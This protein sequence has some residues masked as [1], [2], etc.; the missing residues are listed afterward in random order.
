MIDYIVIS[1]TCVGQGIIKQKN[2]YPYNNPFIG[3]LIP[4][5]YDYIKLVNNFKDYINMIPV[6]GNVKD[7]SLF[8]KQNKCKYYIHKDIKTPYP[9]IYLAD[10]EIHF[11][12]ENNNEECIKKFLNRLNRLKDIIKN[13]NYKIIFILSFSEL[14]NEHNDINLVIKDYFGDNNSINEKKY[15]IGPPEYNNNN[16]N[17]INIEKW[18]NI[19]LTRDTS[20]IYN[21]NDQI[22]TINLLCKYIE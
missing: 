16:E 12:H 22:F 2:I 18:S 5:D 15:F 17:Y 13:N 7:D 19:K 1:N 14:I 11:I 6:L 10:I 21:F 20:H 8:A 3:S 4:N 9:I